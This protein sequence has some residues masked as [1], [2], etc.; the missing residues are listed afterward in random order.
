MFRE[1]A[2]VWPFR[3]RRTTPRP[4][5]AFNNSHSNDNRLGF[6]RSPGQRPCPKQVLTCH[7]I[8]IDGRLECRWERAAGGEGSQ[9]H[10]RHSHPTGRAREPPFA[11]VGSRRRA[12]ARGAGSGSTTDERALAPSFPDEHG[13]NA[14]AIWAGGNGKELLLWSWDRTL[15]HMMTK[16]DA[17]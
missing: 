16:A 5:V 3:S 14:F 6:R 4:L 1:G 13:L 12:C 11:L 8:E 10:P 15:R 7:W 9:C 17:Q 2:T